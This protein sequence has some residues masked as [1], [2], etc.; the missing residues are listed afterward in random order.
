[1]FRAYLV[2]NGHRYHSNPCQSAEVA[3]AFLSAALSLPG[4]EGGAVEV[5]TACGWCAFV[6][7]TDRELLERC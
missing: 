4:A 3:D 2:A 5:L 7:D 6:P 1:M